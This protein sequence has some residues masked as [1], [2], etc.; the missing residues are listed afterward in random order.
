MDVY[1]GNLSFEATEA[2]LQQ[3]FTEYGDVSSVII[4]KDRIS[5]NP[6]GFAFVEMPYEEHAI[7]AIEA[8]HRTRIKDRVVMVSGAASRVER[9]KASLVTEEASV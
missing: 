4:I 1:V 3:A 7:K 5:S 2:D 6:L 9:R 8:L